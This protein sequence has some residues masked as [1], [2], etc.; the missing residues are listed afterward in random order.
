MTRPKT[1]WCDFLE[2]ISLGER[3]ACSECGKDKRPHSYTRQQWF[4]TMP[5]C[6]ICLAEIGKGT[7]GPRAFLRRRDDARQTYCQRW[8]RNHLEKMCARYLE[9]CGECYTEDENKQPQ[10]FVEPPLRVQSGI[11]AV[12]Y[13]TAGGYGITG[14]P[15]G[16]RY[17][18]A[19]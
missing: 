3:K 16:S 1:R 18:G 12:N 7:N 6:N 4:A 15:R 14:R 5:V 13:E 8:L 17:G 9:S 2:D 19:E 10:C 11:Q